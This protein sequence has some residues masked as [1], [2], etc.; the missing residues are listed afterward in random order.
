APASSR[1]RASARARRSSRCRR[2]LADSS[3]PPASR[4]DVHGR[5]TH[6]SRHKDRLRAVFALTATFLVVEA[7]AGLGT[8]RPS[9]LPSLAPPP[10]MLVDPG[11]LLRSLCAVCFAE[12][13]ATA[14]K[15]YGYYR[16]EILAALVNGVVIC[17]LA[18]GI[19]IE[20]Y[21]RLR[22]PLP[23]AGWPV[24]AV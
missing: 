20:A 11:G 23:V 19:L 14:E 4:P 21:E 8:R 2:R 12:R 6:G 15:T 3:R 22:R 9:L 10:H 24:L 16:V 7:V 5:E 18:A 13:P 17:L 1:A